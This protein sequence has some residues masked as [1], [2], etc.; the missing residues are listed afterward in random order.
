M[1]S[2]PST[3]YGKDGNRNEFKCTL[4]PEKNV[5]ARILTFFKPAAK[6]EENANFIFLEG[7]GWCSFYQNNEK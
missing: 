5:Q 3:C 7:K 4:L 2:K 1:F 6:R